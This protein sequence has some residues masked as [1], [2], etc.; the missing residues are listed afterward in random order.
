MSSQNRRKYIVKKILVMKSIKIPLSKKIFIGRQNSQVESCKS[1]LRNHLR[2]NFESEV[3]F[4]SYLND[5]DNRNNN[6][7]VQTDNE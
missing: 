1:K 3:S 4:F 7:S 5:G 6:L 2:E